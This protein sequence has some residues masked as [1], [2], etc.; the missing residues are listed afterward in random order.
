MIKNIENILSSLTGYGNLVTVKTTEFG[1][2]TDYL[3]YSNEKWRVYN[4]AFDSKDVQS[5]LIT[6]NVI[7]I[8]LINK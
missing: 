2:W 1:S 6:E 4:I 8:E 7:L 5:I 3:F